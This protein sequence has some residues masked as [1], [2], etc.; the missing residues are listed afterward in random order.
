MSP[1]C[2]AIH[3]SGIWAGGTCGRDTVPGFETCYF[4][5]S[6]SEMHDKIVHL[7]GL[8]GALE[9]EIATLKEARSAESRPTGDA[10]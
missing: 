3:K 1:T 7:T 10:T 5:T 2:I 6:V 8:G 9:R 4:H